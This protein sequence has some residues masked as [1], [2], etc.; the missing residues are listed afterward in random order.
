MPIYCYETKDGTEH[1]DHYYHIGKAP[2]KIKL[3]SG[4]FAT[5][6]VRPCS[7]VPSGEKE[8]SKGLVSSAAGV[9]PSQIGEAERYAAV[10]G[11]PTKYTPDGDPVFTS[12][13]HRKKFLKLN[14]MIDKDSYY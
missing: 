4:K 12:A 2:R 14:G 8:W 5:R 6:A 7:V 11:V 13:S 9:L 1:E 10:N 3:A